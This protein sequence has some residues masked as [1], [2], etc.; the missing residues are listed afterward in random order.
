MTVKKKLELLTD[1]EIQVIR[2]VCKEMTN[3]EIANELELSPRTVETHR[4]RIMDRLGI[5]STIGLVYFAI[6]SKLI[7]IRIA[8]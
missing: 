3:E 7:K 8:K 4:A 5:K 2:L 6:Q 1:R